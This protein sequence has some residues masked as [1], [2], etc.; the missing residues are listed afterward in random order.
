MS[1]TTDA[2]SKAAEMARQLALKTN[3]G[4]SAGTSKGPTPPTNANPW[5]QY[6]A[7]PYG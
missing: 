4:G 2:V 5:A 7:N 6:A 3:S 1:I